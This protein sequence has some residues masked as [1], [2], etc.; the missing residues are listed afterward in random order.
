M[1]ALPTVNSTNSVAW[2]PRE[3]ILACAHDDAE[4]ARE[5]VISVIGVDGV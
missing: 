3:H 2:H 4:A 5:V 1:R